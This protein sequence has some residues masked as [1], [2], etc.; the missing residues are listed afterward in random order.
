MVQELASSVDKS[1]PALSRVLQTI[2]QHENIPRKKAK[3]L[4]RDTNSLIFLIIL[5]LPHF[6]F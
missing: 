4:V 2:S 3:F 6:S 1:D 5:L